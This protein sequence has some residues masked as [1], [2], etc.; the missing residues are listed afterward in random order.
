MDT[1]EINDV[2]LVRKT[3]RAI[4]IKDDDL[5]D[6]WIPKSQLLAGSD[7]VERHTEGDFITIEIPEWLAYDKELI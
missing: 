1:V 2:L 5:K 7:N 6:H 4:C 3:D